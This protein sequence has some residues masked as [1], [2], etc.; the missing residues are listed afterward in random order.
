MN[1]NRD[2]SLELDEETFK[3]SVRDGSASKTASSLRGF[4]QSLLHKS[5]DIALNPLNYADKTIVA[6]KNPG[7]T[8]AS[9]YTMSAYSGMLFNS[10]C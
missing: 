9:P 3:H 5:N 4:A 1:L 2:G 6:Y 10:Y 7:K 8:F